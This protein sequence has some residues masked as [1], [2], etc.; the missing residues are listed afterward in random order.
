[1]EMNEKIKKILFS[2]RYIFAAVFLL[3]YIVAM[4]LILIQD[5]FDPA[6]K[7]V[8]RKAAAEQLNKDPNDLTDEDFA[9]ITDFQLHQENLKDIKL[10]AKFTNIEHFTLMDLKRPKKEFPKWMTILSRL[11][12]VD[13]ESKNA[14]DLSPLKDLKN[15]KTLFCQSVQIKNIQPLQNLTNLEELTII[16]VPISSIKPLKNLTKLQELCIKVTN[17]ADIKLIKQ[18]PDLK[19]LSII[20]SPVSDLEPLKDCIN[21]EELDISHTNVSDLGPIRGLVNLRMLDLRKTKVS[22]LEPITELSNLEKLY[23]GGNLILEIDMLKNL[24]NLKLLYL[25]E[26]FNLKEGQQESLKKALPDLEIT[27]MGSESPT[28][29]T[30]RA[31]GMRKAPKRD[32]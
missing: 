21:L 29:R 27:L 17:V 3:L 8:I 14:I 7:V 24:T 9:Q 31:G 4:V 1:M 20:Y 13:L 15:L 10:L 30:R 5:Q 26:C 25:D 2:K 28:T 6:S 12:L 11:G 19:K 23:I 32:Q 22:D 18:F 16:N